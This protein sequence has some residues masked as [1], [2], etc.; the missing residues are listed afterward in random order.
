LFWSDRSQAR[1]S[2]RL[3]APPQFFQAR[4]FVFVSGDNDLA[5]NL[6]RNPVFPAK[7][8]HRRSARD[9]QLRFQRPRFVVN[10]G[11][12]DAAVVAALM[13]A[14]AIFFL[15]QQQ[16]KPRKAPRDLESDGEPD[17]ASTDDEDIAA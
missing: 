15:H 10:T 16:A 9:A 7:L 6:M 17:N 14:D 11:V 2:I 8:H 12:N 1:E 4:K 5:A 13:P 3:A